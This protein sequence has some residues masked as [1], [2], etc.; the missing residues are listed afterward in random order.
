MPMFNLYSKRRKRAGGEMSD[1]YVYDSA[2]QAL[3]AQIVHILRDTLGDQEESS[4]ARAHAV[5]ELIVDTLCRE[6]GVFELGSRFKSHSRDYRQELINFI[7]TEGNV[8]RFLDAVELSF[9]CVDRFTRA[10]DYLFRRNGAQLADAALAELNQR[11]QENCM[12][13]AFQS[14]QIVRVDSQ[15]IH[16]QVVIPALQ[17]LTDRK[18]SG[19]EDE[20]LAAHEHHRAGRDKECLNECLK[21]L[22]S[23]LKS[24]CTAK[25]WTYKPT[26]TANDLIGICF[27]NKLIPDF[28]QSHFASLRSVLQSGIPTS[29][30]K[31]GA[32][33]QGAVVQS[34]PKHITGYVL[35]MTASTIVFLEQAS[36]ST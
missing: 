16:S 25:G 21:A 29:R 23:M 17:L 5:Y 7:L 18:F 9:Q 2:P 24:I 32:H 30:N 12:G 4:G 27:R 3:R 20:F 11:F 19:A 8:D 1:V 15:L 35:H 22:E 28:W 33:G 36:K 31:L 10:Y 14:D 26:D 34:V 6:Y 13:Y